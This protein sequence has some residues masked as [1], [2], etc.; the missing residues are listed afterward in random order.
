MGDDRPR[1]RV[2]CMDFP[3][4]YQESKKIFES[5]LCNSEHARWSYRCPEEGPGGDLLTVD[6]ARL[7]P[8]GATSLLVIS[9]GLH[10]VEGPVGMPMLQI[11]HQQMVRRRSDAVGLLMIHA[12]NPFGFAWSAGRIRRGLISTETSCSTA[13]S[14]KALPGCT[15]RWTCG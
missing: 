1:F 4:S 2:S 11:A 9:T 10:G 13:K 8:A 6:V 3:T 15:K 14:I 7:G 5:M 12:L